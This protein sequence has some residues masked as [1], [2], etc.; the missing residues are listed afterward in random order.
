M[1]ITNYLVH[2]KTEA[3]FNANKNQLRND[4]V[5]F[6]GDA[7]IIHTHGTDYYCGSGPVA[8]KSDLANYATT[9]ALTS[10]LAGKANTSHTHTTS[11]ITDLDSY[12]SDQL[13]DYLPLSGGTMTGNLDMNENFIWFDGTRSAIGVESGDIQI[14]HGQSSK[15]YNFGK[16]NLTVDGVAVSLEGHTHTASQVSGLATVATTG[17][18]ND[19]INLPEDSKNAYLL[20]LT[21]LGNIT[22]SGGQA[23]IGTDAYT[24]LANAFNNNQLI[25]V[26]IL[27]ENQN[28]IMP[29]SAYKYGSN[30]I[31]LIFEMAGTTGNFGIYSDGNCFFSSTEISISADNITGLADVATSGSYNDLID[32]PNIPS[33]DDIATQSWVEEQGYLTNSGNNSMLEWSGSDLYFS[34]GESM[35]REEGITL[36]YDNPGYRIMVNTGTVLTSDNYSEYISSTDTKN[37]TGTSNSTDKLYLVGCKSQSAYGVQTYSNNAVYTQSSQLYATQMNATNGFYETSDAR[38][39]NFKDDIRALDVVSKIPTKYFTWKKDEVNEN[40]DPKLHIGTSAQEI[41]KIYP[42]LVTENEEGELSVDYARLSVIALAAIKELK[43]EIDVL[44]SASVKYKF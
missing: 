5:A 27:S 20:D 32:K 36:V 17:S 6:V 10:G 18:Y 13:L 2:F 34:A 24:N 29:V 31:L 39:K 16:D 3:T 38:L 33:M 19:L 15:T 37:T 22:G 9:S 30:A 41:Q 1:A 23:N 26:L 21:A 14:I 4:A 28:M 8:L 12:L 7:T 40:S 42:D 44:K 43:K 25:Y 35:P 11:N